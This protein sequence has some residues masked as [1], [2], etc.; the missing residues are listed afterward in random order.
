MV[1]GDETLNSYVKK[2]C[3]EYELDG[4]P[5]CLNHN[6]QHQHVTSG[7]TNESPSIA[8]SVGLHPHDL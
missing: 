1:E 4:V 7:E 6:Q 3:H 5:H 8:I 2:T